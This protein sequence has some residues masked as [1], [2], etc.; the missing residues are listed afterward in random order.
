[1]KRLLRGR[2]SLAQG[3]VAA[4]LAIGTAAPSDASAENCDPDGGLP[5]N[6]TPPELDPLL[7]DGDTIVASWTYQ[8][9]N[10]GEV[11]LQ[12]FENGEWNTVYEQGGLQVCGDSQM[13]AIDGLDPETEYSVRV[14]VSNQHFDP[15][16]RDPGTCSNTVGG[17][18]GSASAGSDGLGSCPGFVLGEAPGRVAVQVSGTSATVSWED[19]TNRE[20]S[21]LVE[22]WYGNDVRDSSMVELSANTESVVLTGLEPG[23]NDARVAAVDRCGNRIWTDA[24]SFAVQRPR[25]R[26]RR[27][28]PTAVSA[29][30][31]TPW[32]MSLRWNDNSD[33]EST[34]LVYMRPED[35]QWA[36]VDRVGSDS[37]Q[38]NLDQLDANSAYDFKVC[39]VGQSEDDP[40]GTSGRALDRL[41]TLSMGVASRDADDWEMSCTRVFSGHTVPNLVMT[42]YEGTIDF[43][44]TASESAVCWTESVACATGQ[45]TDAALCGWAQVT[46]TITDA[47]MCGVE[48]VFGWLNCGSCLF[49]P[50]CSCQAPASCQVERDCDPSEETCEANTCT[51]TIM[52][53]ETVCEG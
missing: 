46:E 10:N 2:L 15:A 16:Y 8:E 27:G 43:W 26:T 51:Q 25:T 19:R 29:L 31:F 5:S 9:E 7:I 32:G 37:V 53:E 30:S 44:E 23:T 45:V 17:T 36:V 48:T 28:A 12:L 22:H 3:C 21:Y 41:A 11:R 49:G 33:F 39:G 14:C 38:A 6:I 13:Q 40:F 50:N 42:T 4:A 20:V 34:Y 52:C 18:T 24:R 47:A 35:G 1:M